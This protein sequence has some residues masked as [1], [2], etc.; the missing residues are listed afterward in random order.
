M[1]GVLMIMYCIY[2]IYYIC[3]TM[4]GMLMI[5]YHIHIIYIIYVPQ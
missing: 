4:R 3:A 1:R 5:M 2:N